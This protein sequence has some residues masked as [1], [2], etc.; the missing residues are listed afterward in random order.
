MT[1]IPFP[2]F[3]NNR[4]ALRENQQNFRVKSC[5]YQSAISLKHRKNYLMRQMNPSSSVQAAAAGY[6]CL[7][8]AGSTASA[9]P[10]SAAADPTGS[11]FGLSSVLGGAQACAGYA[12]Y[13][14]NLGRTGDS[15]RFGDYLC[16]YSICHTNI[17][18]TGG[19]NFLN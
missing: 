12:A 14:S 15:D 4:E 16:Q 7:N 9:F 19:S 6:G 13:I 8:Y 10:C 18:F 1:L 3:H 5:N 2:E 11:T 17:R